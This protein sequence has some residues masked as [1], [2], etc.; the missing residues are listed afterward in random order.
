MVLGCVKDLKKYPLF[1]SVVVSKDVVVVVVHDLVSLTMSFIGMHMQR[2]WHLVNAEN[3]TVG[4]VAVQIANI[5]RGKHKPTY[6]PGKDMGDHVVVVNAQKVQFTGKKWKLKLYRWHTGY[7]GGLKSRTAEQMLEQNPCK[8]LRK[9]VLGMM[10]R[11]RLRRNYIE[12]RLWIYAGP[13]HHFPNELPASVPPLAPV[14]RA[15]SGNFTTFGLDHYAHP[16]TFQ[17]NP[18]IPKPK[19]RLRIPKHLKT[20]I[21]PVNVQK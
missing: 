6:M 14:P 21:G 9:A 8:I 12:K 16:D 11:N 15:N 2:A 3:Q 18:R 10:E 17:W 5:L 7:P 1:V 13:D 19:T 4:R 20:T